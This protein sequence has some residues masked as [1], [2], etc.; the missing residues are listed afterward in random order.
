VVIEGLS[1]AVDLTDKHD[2]RI[3]TT[4][5]AVGLLDTQLALEPGAGAFHQ[6]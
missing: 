2:T 6:T 1:G 4:V 5:H 3:I